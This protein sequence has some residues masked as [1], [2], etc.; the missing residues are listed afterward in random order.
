MLL[1]ASDFVQRYRERKEES[2]DSFVLDE[3]VFFKRK[4]PVSFAEG[5]PGAL[6]LHVM[7]AVVHVTGVRGWWDG[8]SMSQLHRCMSP[9]H[10]RPSS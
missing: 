10:R 2:L 7:S 1:Q 6:T 9:W 3:S 4:V 5:P 8:D